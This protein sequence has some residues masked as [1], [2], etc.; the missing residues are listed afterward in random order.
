M[1]LNSPLL[2]RGQDDFGSGAFQASRGRR[3]HKGIDIACYKGTAV[4]SD[5]YGKVTKIGYPYN[6]DDKRKKHFRYVQVTDSLGRD[7]RYFYVIPSVDVGD[8]V[9]RGVLLGITQ[10]I[11]EAYNTDLKTMTDHFHYEV[12]EDGEYLNPHKVLETI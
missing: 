6:Q 10:G 4:G 5:V 12:K 7:H 3:K 8:I 11:A 2:I 1:I 9:N